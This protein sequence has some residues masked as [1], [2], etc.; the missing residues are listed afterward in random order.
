LQA[1]LLYSCIFIH[2]V[3][4]IVFRTFSQP[5]ANEQYFC[6]VPVPSQNLPVATSETNFTRVAD[7]L[8]ADLLDACDAGLSE[9]SEADLLGGILTIATPVGHYVVN[10]HAVMQQVWLSSPVSGAWHFVL[11]GTQWR[12]TR[13]DDT[14]DA[15]L[16][17]ELGLVVGG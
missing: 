11:Q 4:Q 2:F 6:T 8:L 1:K 17:R 16:L 12:A 3:Q 13:S 5:F 9:G 14:L 10:K 7:R 15:L